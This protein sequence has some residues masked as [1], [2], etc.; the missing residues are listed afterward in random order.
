MKIDAILSPAEFG[1]LVRRDLGATTCVVF[2]ILRATTCMAAAIHNGAAGILPVLEIEDALRAKREHPEALLAGER[3]GVRITA[4]RTGHEDFDLG[5]S[6]REFT[7]E[8][9]KGRKIITTTTNGTRAL[10]ACAGS[11]SVFSGAY[12]NLGATIDAVLKAQPEQLLV[13]CSGTGE[14]LALEDVVVAGR[15]LMEFTRLSGGQAVLSDSARALMGCSSSIGSDLK[16]AFSESSNG[17]R[18]LG[19]SD[20]G[21][22]VAYA[23]SRDIHPVAV[24]RNADGWLVQK[25]ATPEE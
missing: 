8:R 23:A 6:P 14:L 22:D 16:Q 19:M 9:V 21:A 10:E 11:R 15:F 17:A 7:R 20:L 25:S 4:A 24:R 18:L 13:V 5:N 2:D 12:V 3:G 1:I